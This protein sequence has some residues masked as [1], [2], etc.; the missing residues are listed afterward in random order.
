MTQTDAGHPSKDQLLSSRSRVLL[1]K[2]ATVSVIISLFLR[3]AVPWRGSLWISEA[4][5]ALRNLTTSGQYCPEYV[6]LVRAYLD[7]YRAPLTDET[8]KQVSV[9]V[10]LHLMIVMDW[11]LMS[12][13]VMRAVHAGLS[14]LPKQGARSHPHSLGPSGTWAGTVSGGQVLRRHSQSPS[15]TTAIWEARRLRYLFAPAG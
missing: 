8:R 13:S 6:P 14:I 4:G 12:L 2:A 5:L 15:S 7:P 3:C 9:C 10:W 11:L 1:S